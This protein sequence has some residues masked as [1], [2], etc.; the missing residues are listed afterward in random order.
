[1]LIF[2]VFS[3]LFSCLSFAASNHLK[4]RAFSSWFS[5]QTLNQNNFKSFKTLTKDVL[6]IS[7]IFPF[8]F[9]IIPMTYKRAKNFFNM[10]LLQC[11]SDLMYQ[12]VALYSF[13]V[14]SF[15]IDGLC[16]SK[17]FLLKCFVIFRRF[18][19]I[20]IPIKDDWGTL[21]MGKKW[22][23]HCENGK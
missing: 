15:F 8:L 22:C 4:S 7:G 16:Y 18:M 13:L 14:F 6:L 20:D 17:T 23:V 2:I 10:C 12:H 19:F 5:F 1:M 21:C 11:P 3:I 9:T